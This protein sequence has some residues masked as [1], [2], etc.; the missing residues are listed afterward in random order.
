MRFISENNFAALV[1]TSNATVQKWAENGVYPSHSEDGVKGFYLEELETFPEVE[2]MLH[3]RWDEELHTR[4]LRE[5]TSV[6][7]FA[8]GGGLALGLSLAG[9]SHVLL[10]EFDKSA[11][12]TLRMNHPEWDI[13]EGDVRN[14]DFTPLRDKVDFLSGGFP[15]QAFS[16]AGKQG[17][18]DDTRG[19][20]FF[21]LARAVNEIRP[22]VFMGE[23]VKGLT[24]HD[25]GR[26]FS[27]IKN[28]IAELGYTLVEPRVLKAIM[29]QV[30]QKRERLILIAIRNDLA[31]KVSYYWPS[32]YTQ[33]L[34]LRD[35]LYKSI[36]Y[37]TDV[38]QSEGVKYPLKK[39]KVLE[40]VPQGGDWRNLP[41]D[42]AK[43]YM[44]GSWFLGGGK[45]GMA[46]RLSLDEPSLTLTCSPCQKQTER[47]HPLE[48]RPLTVREYARIQT[49]PDSWL[50]A[51]TMSDKYKQIGNAVPVN[52]AWAVGRSLIR[53]FNDIQTIEPVEKRDC[54][55]A[56]AQIIDRLKEGKVK[57]ALDVKIEKLKKSDAKIK[58]LNFFDLLA[59]Y[60]DGI[61][62]SLVKESQTIGYGKLSQ[63][64][65]SKNVLVC[66][67]KKD[68][69][70]RYLDKS[71]TIYYTGKRF[72]ST[73]ELDKLCY[74]IPY[75]S[76]QGIRD[77][78]RIK[79]ARVGTRKEG[80]A[81][82]NPNDYRLVFE[83]EYIKQLFPEYKHPVLEIWHT[84]TDTIL[85]ELVP[86]F[87]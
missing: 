75:L 71:A 52:L 33:V 46:R 69:V 67:V 37:D 15:C 80:Q 29:Y 8:G 76:G 5:Y 77:L 81:G 35:A 1:G 57:K 74:F 44:G 79:V 34:T 10:N 86:S 41:E 64:D 28:T 30:P 9:F 48:T 66:F 54:S 2:D 31:E 25:H 63:V 61:I 17:G 11:C 58:Q 39:Q 32:P 16:Y 49:F 53:L 4:P 22:K 38:P 59:E 23:N 85:E 73:V 47:C 55:E 6:E 13:I 21:E 70:S 40:L 20:L 82:N 72:P 14:V 24:S 18:F 12:N 3:S 27:T 50:F 62:S 56:V 51:G 60:P 19:T 68:N 26:T 87:F 43:E 84:Y 7:L 36:I 42:V 65:M 78:Y 45:T 83:I